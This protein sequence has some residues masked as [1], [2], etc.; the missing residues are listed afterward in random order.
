MAVEK[1]IALEEKDVEKERHVTVAFEAGLA[2]AAEEV[3]KGHFAVAV[4][5]EEYFVLVVQ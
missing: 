3:Q 5:V 2:A 1:H 4:E